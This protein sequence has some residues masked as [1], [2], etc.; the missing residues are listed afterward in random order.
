MYVRLCASKFY[1]QD[2]DY[3]FT[4]HDICYSYRY[5]YIACNGTTT[6][7]CQQDSG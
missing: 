1:T 2:D 3:V 5:F 4:T 6:Q 7:D